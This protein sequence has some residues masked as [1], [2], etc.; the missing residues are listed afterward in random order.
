MC[1][2]AA[3]REPFAVPQPAI[4]PEIHQPFYVHCD[5]PPEVAFDGVISVDQ[6]ADAQDLLVRHLMDAP[7]K[8]YPHPIANLERFG[9][10]DTMNVSQPDW[11]E[12]LIW[13]IDASDA[14]HLRFSSKS[15]NGGSSNFSQ[16]DAL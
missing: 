6:F 8:R 1:T 10:P 14:R 2:L 5:L 15:R 16:G 3:N 13:Y 12:L 4:A 11:D 9:P 7:F